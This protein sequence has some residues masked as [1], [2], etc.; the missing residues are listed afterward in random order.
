MSLLK[1]ILLESKKKNPKVPKLRDRNLV[2]KF[3]RGAGAGV[4]QDK[5]GPKASRARQKRQWRKEE[6]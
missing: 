1:E 6:M 5:I 2:A 4:H 3:A